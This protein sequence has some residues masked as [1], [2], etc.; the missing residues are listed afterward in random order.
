MNDKKTLAHV[1]EQFEYVKD[2]KTFVMITEVAKWLIKRAEE[3]DFLQKRDKD[4]R[5][6]LE[7]QDKALREIA[8]EGIGYGRNI[9]IET[10]E[11]FRTGSNIDNNKFRLKVRKMKCVECDTISLVEFKQPQETMYFC[12][13][14]MERMGDMEDITVIQD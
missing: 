3:V 1:K 7:A 6:W 4:H 9:A 10:L 12:P 13:I 2:T 11:G 8:K 5:I 14:C